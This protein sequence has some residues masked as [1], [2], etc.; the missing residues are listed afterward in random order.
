VR[1][2]PSIFTS[3]S[4]CCAS[5]NLMASVKASLYQKEFPTDTE[6]LSTRN[7]NMHDKNELC[8]SWHNA[9]NFNEQPKIRHKFTCWHIKY[10]L[11]TKVLHVLNFK[12]QF[13]I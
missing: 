9:V 13:L 8:T 3:S 6:L 7:L 2:T 11:Q 10:N 12:F 4:A 5:N 1:L